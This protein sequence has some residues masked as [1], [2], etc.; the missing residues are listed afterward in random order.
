MRYRGESQGRRSVIYSN[1]LKCVGKSTLDSTLI[2]M[3]HNV[4]ILVN[5]YCFYAIV[6]SSEIPECIHTSLI[7]SSTS[8]VE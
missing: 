6:T 8:G 5:L 7:S 4:E 3:Y 2:Y 1:I